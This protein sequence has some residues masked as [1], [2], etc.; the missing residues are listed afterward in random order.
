[1]SDEH[2][3]YSSC[4]V[5]LLNVTQ[6]VD[7]LVDIPLCFWETGFGTSCFGNSVWMTGKDP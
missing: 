6:P 3:H 4:S 7:S 5:L 2:A 1:M